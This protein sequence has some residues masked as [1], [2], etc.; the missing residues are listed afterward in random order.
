M[1][2]DYGLWHKRLGA[3][4]RIGDL[5]GEQE[6]IYSSF[7]V[8]KTEEDAELVIQIYGLTDELEVRPFS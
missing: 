2:N 4:M 3:W 6:L 5:T 7:A 1:S 8:Y